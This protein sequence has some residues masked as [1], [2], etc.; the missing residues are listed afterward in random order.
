MQQ[1]FRYIISILTILS[2]Y[3]I[4]ELS[5]QQ[6]ESVSFG[7]TYVH[8]SGEM[9]VFGKHTF[10]VGSTTVL[11]GIIGT[12]RNGDYGLFS[13]SDQSD[14]WDDADDDSYVDGY[15]K[16]YGGDGFVFPI[17]DNG[18]Y[19]PLAIS[20]GAGTSAAYYG[21][22][23]D[24]AITDD[25]FG[26]IFPVLPVGGPF[27]TDLLAG[28]IFQMSQVEYWDVDGTEPTKLTLTWDIFSGIND[29]TD[30]DV[31]R[32]TIIG[33]DGEKWVPIP[34]KIDILFLN[35]NSSDPKFNAGISNR[36]KGSIS[37]VGEVIPDQYLAYT[38][39]AIAS[40]FIGDFVWED[41]NRD[42]IQDPGEPGL[43][44]VTVDLYDSDDNL[45][46]T[47]V[48]DVNGRFSFEGVQPGRY[49][50]K[51]SPP[52][53]YN[54][55]LP[56]QGLA[57]LNSD[58][59]FDRETAIFTLGANDID[60]SVDGG[61]YRTGSIGDYVWL[62]SDGDG[63]QDDN[64]PPV[65][66]IRI[67]LLDM[68]GELLASTVS[69]ANGFYSFTNIPPGD[70]LITYEM[71]EGYGFAPYK[72]SLE[73][74]RDSDIDPMTGRSDIIS[75]LSG[76]VNESVDIG[77][78]Q[79][80]DYVASVDMIAP[81]CGTTN[82]SITVTIDGNSAPYTY[83]W[84]NGETTAEITDLDTGTYNLV[85]SD[86]RGCNR[87]FSID[88][89]YTADCSMACINLN[90]QV[91]LEGP[92]DDD[93]QKMKHELAE[94]GYLPGQRPT[95]FFGKFTEAGQPYGRTPYDHFGVEGIDNESASVADNYSYYDENTTDWV[96]VSLRTV[97]SEEYETCTRAGRLLDDGT[98]V[99]DE[100]NCCQVDPS[101]EYYVVIEHRNHLIVMSPTV[102]PVVNNEI[103]YDFRK[104]NSFRSLFGFGQKEIAPGV[105]AMYSANGDQY[106]APN[107]PVDINIGDQ[108]EWLEENGEHSSY[109]FMDFDLNGDA[110]VQDKGYYLENIGIFSDVPKRR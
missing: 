108:S 20:A 87:A 30:G 46:A 57:A 98:I 14:G 19:R 40:G 37:T 26:G 70:Y 29:M 73:T 27:P 47:L 74:D 77:M 52:P 88:V 63:Y 24:E 16:Y 23:P 68:N 6:C 15:V 2:L 50:L 80:C 94:L 56:G 67:E 60:F 31:S 72:A 75:L 21:V 4:S 55:T 86:N 3:G 71:P 45:I 54:V 107:S 62:D 66:N 53:G 69:D 83:A 90:V 61:F 76:Q 103:N 84:S 96:L 22:D 109:Y 17:G 78:S 92:Y 99:F 85:I 9:N 35:R 41:L 8:E 11:P 48:S 39:G 18:S 91:F 5:A 95:T 49:Y 1:S 81:D 10:S 34:S 36:S 110:N 13:F 97:A 58:V 42:G 101:K 79:S 93:A 105:F 12:E 33:Y 51:F 89:D 7:N 32:L 102:L 44:G 106:L 100:D 104:G 59:G 25:L 82:G 64:E 43:E 65:P 38:F 28:G